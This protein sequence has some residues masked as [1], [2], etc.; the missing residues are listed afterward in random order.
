MVFGKRSKESTVRGIWKHY[1]SHGHYQGVSGS[2][3]VAQGR[4]DT[5]E[6]NR[7]Q[8]KGKRFVITSA[9]NNTHIHEKFF[10]SLMG[11]CEANDAELMVSPFYYNLS[12]F[13]NLGK[14]HDQEEEVWFDTRIQPYLTNDSI[15][16]AK[17]LVFCGE[18]NILPTRVNPIS[19]Y[20]S[21]TGDQSG[22][23]P[24]AKLQLESLP[25]PMGDP[26]KLMYTTGAITQRNYIPK[27]AGQKAEWHHTF[28]ALYVYVDEDGDWFVRQLNAES[29]TGCF[30]DLVNHY[31]PKGKD[32][33]EYV[34][35]AVNL[36]DIH[37]DKL[38]KEVADMCWGGTD[39]LLGYL[40]PEH[41]FIHDIHDHARRNHHN[42]KDPYFLF[43]QFV[44]GKE[45]VRDEVKKTVDILEDIAK[46]SERVIV[47]ESNHDLAL[48]RW[49]KEQDYRRDP[50]NAEFFLDMQLTNYQTMAAGEKLQTFK[51]ACEKVAE[52]GLPPN[53][54]F[55]TTDEQYRLHGI[56]FGQHGHNGNNGARGSTRAF[57][58]QGIKFNIGHQ[59]SCG[60][61]DGVYVSGAC[62]IETDA[63]YTKGG[64]SWSISHIVTYPNGKRA[65]ITCKNGKFM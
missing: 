31:T 5:P 29:D 41:V 45:S 21:Y 43:Q 8:A 34:I 47:V 3:P 32:E 39:S 19:G 36:G 17:G 4:I 14:N 51:T 57:Q 15:Q 60:I 23:I 56:E 18:L 52:G 1:K 44:G 33:N 55:L 16:L 48:E 35:S 10:N 54:R 7:V 46:I 28:A 63:G 49:L 58:M 12:G 40:A 61:K 42:I 20:H 64:S 62:V 37:V 59:H 27:S 26:A 6:V 25:T 24:H 53:I 2:Q 38:R 50:V 22:I 65:I 13:Q 9:Q 11:F 30:Y